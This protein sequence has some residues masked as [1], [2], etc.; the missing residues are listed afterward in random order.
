MDS[1]PHGREPTLSTDRHYSSTNPPP[2]SL[3]VTHP[4][5]SVRHIIITTPILRVSPRHILRALTG[6]ALIEVPRLR[7]FASP[8]LDIAALGFREI[9]VVTLAGDM[10][11]V[12]GCAAGELF[13][14]GLVDAGLSCYGEG[15]LVGRGGRQEG[16]KTCASGDGRM[17]APTGL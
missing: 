3:D 11:A 10:A 16:V 13:C 14:H 9:P 15:V 5:T 8:L 2:S 6:L 12:L 7:Q 1:T 17:R 4:I